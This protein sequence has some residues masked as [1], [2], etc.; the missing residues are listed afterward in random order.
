MTVSTE[1]EPVIGLE[2]H[3]QLLTASKM[4]CSC[5][6]AYADSPPNRHVCAVCAGM[7]GALPVINARAVEFTLRVALALG[8]RIDPSSKFDRKNYPYPDLPKGYQISQYDMP[9][10]QDGALEFRSGNK[11]RRCGIIRVHL[12]ED[13]GKTTH[14][15][16]DGREVSL[17][18]YNRSGVPLLEIVSRPELHSAEDA[19][20]YFAALRQLLMYIHVCDGNLQEGSMRA[21]VNVSIHRPGEPLGTK[22]E[23]KN[24]NSFRAVQRALEFE[25]YRQSELLAQGEQVVHETRG[26]SEERQ[27]TLGQRSKEMAHDYRYFPE[28]D[29]PYLTFAP[30][31]LAAVHAALP[32]LPAARRE[33]FQAQYGLSPATASVLTAEQPIAE[34]LE[35]TLRAGTGLAPA[36]VANW[37]SGEVLRLLKD[38][39]TPPDAIPVSAD[40][41]AALLRM[42][43]GRDV[44]NTAAKAV[45]EDMF[46]S[47]EPPRAV[48]S[49]LGLERIGDAGLTEELVDR[50]LA[51]NPSKVEQYRAGKLQVMQSLFGDV[52]KLSRGKADPVQVRDALQRRLDAQN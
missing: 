37:I 2:V 45:L 52:M 43:H 27:V 26:W 29:L 42:V 25:V 48:V 31:Q 34:Y 39:N 46:G 22:V 11:T 47:G 7:P 6:A 32:E 21:D 1:F 28:P 19:R 23:I 35:D 9:I 33:R 38:T 30:E 3:A 15:S 4:Y 16:V 24:L 5:S 49:R 51:E 20:E 50:A 13:T 14:T 12:E 17:V 40:D 8:C 44:S 10:G 36:G 41:L 18:D